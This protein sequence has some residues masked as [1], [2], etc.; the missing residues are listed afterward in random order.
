MAMTT[1]NSISVKPAMLK[2]DERP[3]RLRFLLRSF[4]FMECLPNGL[5]PRYGSEISFKISGTEPRV[6]QIMTVTHGVDYPFASW[7]TAA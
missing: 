7:I 4:L 1:S 2:S 5:Q 6:K 3:F